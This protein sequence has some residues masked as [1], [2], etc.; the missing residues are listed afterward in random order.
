MAFDKWGSKEGIFENIPQTPPSD[1][2]ASLCFS[3]CFMRLRQLA[4]PLWAWLS[5]TPNTWIVIEIARTRKILINLT[6]AHM[7]IGW[8]GSSRN[9]IFRGTF[10]CRDCR[11]HGGFIPADV[12]VLTLLHCGGSWS[13]RFLFC[14]FWTSADKQETK[15]KNYTNN[16]IHDNHWKENWT[17]IYTARKY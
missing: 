16:F 14:L 9:M 4:K 6:S 13:W 3:I 15:T 12:L 2:T 7:G 5:A 1:C 8:G 11:L 10:A 17:L